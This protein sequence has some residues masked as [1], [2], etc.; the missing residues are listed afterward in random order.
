MTTHHALDECTDRLPMGVLLEVLKI[1]HGDCQWVLHRSSRFYTDCQ[2]VFIKALCFYPSVQDIMGQMDFLFSNLPAKKYQK[3]PLAVEGSQRTYVRIK[4]KNFSFILVDSL[5]MKKQ[6]HFLLRLKEL[7]SLDLRI[8][9]LKVADKQKPYILLEDLGDQSLEKIVSKNSKFVFSYYQQAIDQIINLQKKALIFSWP[10]FSKKS[11]FEEMLWTQK[12][13]LKHFFSIKMKTVFM[14]ECQKEWKRICQK[15][16][17]FCFL[18][19]HRDYHSRN[20]M[21]KNKKLYMIDFQDAGLFPRFYD[22]VSL[23]YDSYVDVPKKKELKEYFFSHMPAQDA[24]KK[25]LLKEFQLTA[26]QRIFKACGSF[27]SFYVLKNQDTHLSYILP[28]LRS[29]R[30]LL[31][32][33]KEYPFFL[34]L[35]NQ[36]IEKKK[37]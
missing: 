13:L 36:I 11:F 24:D 2:W 35:V 33:Y 17:S 5:T 18:P 26:I 10:H 8:P 21:I 9:K 22:L 28:S 15:I 23:L 34:S 3:I 37:E 6:K 7:K 4:G 20:L 27:A 12:Y 29:L 32:V 19:S 31:R 16:S 25:S 1:L 30:K 14:K